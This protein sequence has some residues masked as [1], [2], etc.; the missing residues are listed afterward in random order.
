VRRLI[1]GSRR[2]LVAA[3]LLFGSARC[4]SDESL[5]EPNRCTTDGAEC[6]DGKHLGVCVG[7]TF[8]IRDCDD[9]CNARNGGGSSLGCSLLD[10]PDECACTLPSRPCEGDGPLTCA[11][12]RYVVSC[13]NGKSQSQIC[14]CKDSGPINL[15]CQY[16]ETGKPSCACASAGEP[17]ASSFWDRCVGDSSLARCEAGVWTVTMC[18]EV[19]APA[20]ALGCV[21]STLRGEAACACEMS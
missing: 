8:T 17:C 13:V 10:G 20:R 15:G 7:G 1:C 12:S 18:D 6:L 5:A 21:F 14:D 4:G 11:A 2:A 9:D 3:V 19:C 16:L